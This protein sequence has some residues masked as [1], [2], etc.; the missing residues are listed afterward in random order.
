[1]LCHGAFNAQAFFDP[2]EL[3]KV[4]PGARQLRTRHEDATLRRQHAIERRGVQYA[5]ENQQF[6]MSTRDPGADP[7]ISTSK[8]LGAEFG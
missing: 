8:I 7:I 3:T 6:S 2:S 1:L 4:D 5:Y